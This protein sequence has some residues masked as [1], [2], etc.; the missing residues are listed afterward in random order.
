MTK[1]T[2]E[3][4]NWKPGQVQGTGCPETVSDLEEHEIAIRAWRLG[5]VD[6]ISRMMGRAGLGEFYEQGHRRGQ[7]DLEK[8]EAIDLGQIKLVK[9]DDKDIDDFFASL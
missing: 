9:F 2:C 7:E 8:A 1:T 4:C 5:Y 3:F 6:A